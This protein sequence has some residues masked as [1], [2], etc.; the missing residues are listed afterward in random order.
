[1]F[2]NVKKGNMTLFGPNMHRKKKR[3]S[4]ELPGKIVLHTFDLFQICWIPTHNY[5][6][7]NF[8]HALDHESMK[9][10]V[11][12]MMILQTAQISP[13][14]SCLTTTSQTSIFQCPIYSNILTRY[15]K[16]RIFQYPK[17]YSNTTEIYVVIF[18]TQRDIL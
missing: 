1:M 14:L 11:V 12:R 15:A 7:W 9:F 10:E 3:K 16:P 13:L 8:G 5:I 6:T 18:L 17:I 2:Q 4:N